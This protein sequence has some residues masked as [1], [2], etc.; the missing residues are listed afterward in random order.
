MKSERE[1]RGGREE[2]R[3]RERGKGKNKQTHT[4][5]ETLSSLFSLLFHCLVPLYTLHVRCC[6]CLYLRRAAA[7]TATWTP[8]ADDLTAGSIP[9]T[10]E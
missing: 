2:E 10:G 6:G 4:K 9:L 5:Y 8:R 3:E 1:G 7:R